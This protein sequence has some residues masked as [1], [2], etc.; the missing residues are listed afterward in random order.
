MAIIAAAICAT[1][2]AC[3]PSSDQTASSG[4]NTAAAVP[5]PSSPDDIVKARAPQ[6]EVDLANA[7][8]T[9]QQDVDA[10]NDIVRVDIQKRKS[11][12]WKRVVLAQGEFHDWSA[13]VHDISSEGRIT[14]DLPGDLRLYADTAPN[15]AL[16]ATIKTLSDNKTPVIFSGHIDHADMSS[17]AES[18]DENFPTCFEE[19]MGVTGCELDLTSLRTIGQ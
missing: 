12:I 6:A 18:D 16:F 5:A 3:G 11:A 17:T 14:L 4:D 7:H 8:I 10:P 2:T 19:A 1:L 13:E 15:S 9:Y